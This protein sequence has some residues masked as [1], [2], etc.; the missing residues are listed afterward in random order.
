M[1]TEKTNTCYCG[2]A[3]PYSECCQPFH[4]QQQYPQTAEQLMRSRYS[5]CS[6]KKVDYLTLTTWPQQQ[7]Q[8]D[9]EEVAKWLDRT[10]WH[11][12][13]IT[14]TETGQ[15]GDTRG[16]VCFEAH[17]SE[18]PSDEIKIHDEDS[19][20]IQEKNRWYFIHPG[21]EPQP[22]QHTE[23]AAGR[24]DPCPCGSGK[25]FKKCCM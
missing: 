2:N 1:D 11:Q 12:L 5:A 3:Q 25:K 18:P 6:L 7:N 23:K 24:N 16:R 8:L 19:K 22:P 13:N 17:Y 15:P 21:L 14:H 20:F 4:E 9:Q 10:Q